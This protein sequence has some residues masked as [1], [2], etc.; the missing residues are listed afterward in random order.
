M[1]TSGESNADLRDRIAFETGKPC[2][3]TVVRDGKEQNHQVTVGE[4]K[5]D[6]GLTGKQQER[7]EKLGMELQT[8]T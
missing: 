2:G 6:S 4:M 5:N 1:Q 7:N 3:F 8:L